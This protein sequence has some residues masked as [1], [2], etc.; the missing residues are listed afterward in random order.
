MVPI[1]CSVE[2]VLKAKKIARDLAKQ[3]GISTIGVIDHW[4]NYKER[5]VLNGVEL[6][7]DEIWVTDDE[8]LIL[9]KKYLRKLKF[10]KKKSIS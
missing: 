8:A 6:L 7:S 2:L 3:K 5:F 4:V 1:C 9:A 10:S